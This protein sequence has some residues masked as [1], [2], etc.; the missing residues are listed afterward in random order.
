MIHSL[1]E[2]KLRLINEM[3]RK[4]GEF[5]QKRADIVNSI[6]EEIA[7]FKAG[8]LVKVYGGDDFLF[9]ATIIQPIF[10]KKNGIITYRVRKET[11]EVFTNEVYKIT[12]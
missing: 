8:E 3:D 7:E 6:I 12:K 5:M 2:D 11:G 10:L 1:P 9:N 4:I